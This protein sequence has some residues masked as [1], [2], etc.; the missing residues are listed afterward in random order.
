MGPL[1]TR[2]A[3]LKIYVCV[4]LII[5]LYTKQST[6]TYFNQSMHSLVYGHY[7][8]TC[9]HTFLIVLR[10]DLGSDCSSSWSLHTFY[11][12]SIF[13]Y[14]PQEKEKKSPVYKCVQSTP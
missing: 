1:G 8:L 11:L 4:Y 9:L 3:Y 7:T 10:L 14:L 13:A 12:Y 5:R 6:F 2:Y